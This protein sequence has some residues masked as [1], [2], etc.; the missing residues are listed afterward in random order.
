MKSLRAQCRKSAANR[1]K[2]YAA[3]GRVVDDVIDDIGLPAMKGSPFAEAADPFVDDGRALSRL[4]RPG[5]KEA[6]TNINI[7]V[8]AKEKPE[9][10]VAPPPPMMAPPAP[11]MDVPPQGMP[12]MPMRKHGGRVSMD[13]GSG[14]GLGRLEKI[15]DY[16]KKASK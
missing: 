12:P 4:D 5:R 11:P 6:K 1:I 13:S 9:A 3:G 2:G 15:K 16:G 8:A 14:G 7:I 10:P